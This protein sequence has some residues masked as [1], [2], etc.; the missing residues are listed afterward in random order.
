MRDDVGLMCR[1][2]TSFRK[3]S[4]LI[5]RSQLDVIIDN[6][7]TPCAQLG[8]ISFCSFIFT[9]LQRHFTLALQKRLQ[10][11]FSNAIKRDYRGILY[12][13]I[14]CL[15]VSRGRQ[16]RISWK[17]RTLGMSAFAKA[18]RREQKTKL[19]EREMDGDKKR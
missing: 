13:I 18:L 7:I 1:Q 8:S 15:L 11:Q 4:A 19:T 14:Q 12:S 6:A 3:F 10:R 9:R 5:V 2:R 17:C 16:K